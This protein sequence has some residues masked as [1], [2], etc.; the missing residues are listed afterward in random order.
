MKTKPVKIGSS[1]STSTYRLG[2]WLIAVERKTSRSYACGLCKTQSWSQWGA[3]NMENLSV[4]ENL[5]GMGGIK[6]AVAKLTKL[7]ALA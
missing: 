7:S 4:S 6:D 1:K 2:K 5:S 3:S